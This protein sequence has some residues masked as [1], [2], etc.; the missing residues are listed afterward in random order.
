MQVTPVQRLERVRAYRRKIARGGV[1]CALRGHTL[2][3][4]SW[5]PARQ[6]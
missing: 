5:I 2:F 1:S 4:L 3:C 6:N